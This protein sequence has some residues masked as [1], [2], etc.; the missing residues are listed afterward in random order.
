MSEAVLYLHGRLPTQDAETLLR[1]YGAFDGLFLV[2]K[3][4]RHQLVLSVC[5][6]AI[7]HLVIGRDDKTGLMT[8]CGHPCIDSENL[9]MLIDNLHDPAYAKL[10]STK[11]H[12]LK[13]PLTSAVA[14]VP[15]EKL[16]ASVTAKKGKRHDYINIE[17]HDLAV[18]KLSVKA[19]GLSVNPSSS[20]S[21]YVNMD[22]A[23]A[24][25]AGHAYVNCAEDGRPIVDIDH[26][27][28]NVD[29]DGNQAIVGD[30]NKKKGY[31]NVEDYEELN[32][33]QKHVTLERDTYKQLTSAG[34]R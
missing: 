23:G 21:A 27:Y 20:A 30:D 24:P 31:V 28:V 33:S 11:A 3:N 29:E 25:I 26:P 2:R 32:A 7:L 6:E 13:G 15:D 16:P 10:L 17:D 18:R 34:Q 12:M 14:V 19:A 9:P 8:I 1:K 4:R 5:F 22:E